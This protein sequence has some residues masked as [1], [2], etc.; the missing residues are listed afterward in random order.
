MLGLTAAAAGLASSTTM[1]AEWTLSPSAQLTT[2]AQDNPRLLAERGDTETSLGTRATLLVKRQTE[3]FGMTLVSAAGYQRYQ[4]DTGLNRNDQQLNLALDRQGEQFSW[5]GGVAATRDTTLTSELGITGQT[6][7]NQRHENFNYSFGPT[8]QVSERVLM[9]SNLEWQVNRYPS[10]AGELRDYR[11]G[12]AALSTSYVLSDRASVSLSGTA[13]RFSTGD[14]STQS[15][16]ASVSLQGRYA[17]S[18]LW[19]VSGGAGPSWVRANHEQQQGVVYSFSVSRALERSSLS[20]SASR[21]QSPSGFGVLT[22]TDDVRLSF[23]TQFSERLGGS[24]DLGMVRRRDALAEFNVDLQEVRYRHVEAN[25][26]WVVAPNWQLAFG[27][28]N[29]AQRVGTFAES[30]VAQN[31]QAHLTLS[32]TGNPH[33]N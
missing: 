30:P 2:E 16:N 20:L 26:S 23:G 29:Q 19:S 8:W 24:L 27:A 15:D 25:L 1:A 32:W 11:Y 33:V 22:E 9:S 21:S 4:H 31:Y 6:Q 7:L 28:G 17:L 14:S 3:N 18:P 12:T 10:G 5:N 13:G